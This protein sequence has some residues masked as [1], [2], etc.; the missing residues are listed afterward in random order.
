MLFSNFLDLLPLLLLLLL[1]MMKE[2]RKKVPV[3]SKTFLFYKISKNSINKSFSTSKI[4]NFL[5]QQLFS[6]A[7]QVPANRARIFAA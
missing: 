6:G 2:E 7:H 1:M 5:L 3:C 4:I